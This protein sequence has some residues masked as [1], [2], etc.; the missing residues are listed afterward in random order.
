[1]EA[2]AL[3]LASGSTC[4]QAAAVSGAGLTTVKVWSSSC[5]AFKARVV[6]L[7]GELTGRAVG[8]LADGMADAAT[9]L[10]TL[11]N[12]S[13]D[14]AIRL[15]A[16]VALLDCGLKVRESVEIEA[17]LSALEAQS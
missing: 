4:E 1:M 10:R 2:A 9:A 6:A 3:A 12:E 5:P 13:E 11:C 7:R 17:R 15:K 14:E 8:L 16:S